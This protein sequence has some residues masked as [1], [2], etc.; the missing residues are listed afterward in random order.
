LSFPDTGL[1]GKAVILLGV[2]YVGRAFV[3]R[4]GGGG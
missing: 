4:S 2:V 3:A 1:F